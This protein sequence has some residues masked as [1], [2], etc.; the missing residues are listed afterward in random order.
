MDQTIWIAVLILLCMALVV[1]ALIMQA[2]KTTRRQQLLLQDELNRAV[3]RRQ[4]SIDWKE[5][6]RN[7]IIAMDTA[8]RVLLY[9]RLE[10][11]H[12]RYDLINLD[13]I[14]GCEVVQASNQYL[15]KG[16]KGKMQAKVHV[17]G[18]QLQLHTAN[19]PH[20][21]IVFYSEVEDGALAMKELENKAQEWRMAINALRKPVAVK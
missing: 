6:F 5:T 4:L 12:T 17:N 18:I 7:R 16:K 19:G 20:L 21:D 10:D 1:A 9:I 8:E 11:N 3:A 14:K 13:M 2:R 15:E